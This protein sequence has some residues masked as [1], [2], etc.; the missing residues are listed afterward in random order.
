MLKNTTT[1]LHLGFCKIKMLDDVNVLDIP[2]KKRNSMGG[3][4]Q[5][6]DVQAVEINQ[7]GEIPHVTSVKNRYIKK[8]A[9][10]NQ[11]TANV[12]SL[13]KNLGQTRV[14]RHQWKNEI[15]PRLFNPN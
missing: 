10:A 2:E 13:T 7:A 11:K 4:W 14:H 8:T 1:K 3:N 15:L 9:K 5:I 12:M 6:C